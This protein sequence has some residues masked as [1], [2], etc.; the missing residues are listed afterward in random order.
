V[1][2]NYTQDINQRN[3]PIFLAASLVRWKE[4]RHWLFTD[5]S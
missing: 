5:W 4:G 2:N 1:Q 3:R